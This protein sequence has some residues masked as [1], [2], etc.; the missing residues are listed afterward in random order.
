[1]N[2]TLCRVTTCKGSPQV[3]HPTQNYP[4]SAHRTMLTPAQ[5][6][7]R[8]SDG[9]VGLWKLARYRT[10]IGHRASQS[11]HRPAE[12]PTRMPA[13]QQARCAQHSK[14]AGATSSPRVARAIQTQIRREGSYHTIET[15]THLARRRKSTVGQARQNQILTTQP[16]I[17]SDI[18]R[19]RSTSA[20][21][22]K[23]APYT[24]SDQ[25]RKLQL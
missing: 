20:T 17:E 18:Q 8:R 9:G 1:M 4:F 6:R 22:T 7:S 21:Q 19:S 12:L 10:A 13:S 24:N 3:P 23:H 2:Q 14:R 5:N 25:V 11:P 15:T 16:A